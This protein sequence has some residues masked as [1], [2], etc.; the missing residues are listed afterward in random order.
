MHVFF[1]HVFCHPHFPGVPVPLPG[2]AEDDGILH[3]HHVESSPDLHWV[4]VRECS[5]QGCDWHRTIVK[6]E[7]REKKR[8]P[9]VRAGLEFVGV[10]GLDSHV[11]RVFLHTSVLYGYPTDNA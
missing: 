10:S 6:Y 4:H 8:K 1:W 9:F 2:G 7:F 5:V 3:L 11:T